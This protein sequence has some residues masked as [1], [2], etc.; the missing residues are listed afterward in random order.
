MTV[1]YEYKSVCCGHL[2]VEQRAAD[3]PMFSS[4]CNACGG[5]NYELVKETVLSKTAE[6]AYAKEQPIE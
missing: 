4:V 1:K 5:L 2:Y 3:E 6:V